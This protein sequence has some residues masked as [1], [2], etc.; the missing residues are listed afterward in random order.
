MREEILL[1]ETKTNVLIVLMCGFILINQ[2]RGIEFLLLAH[3][4]HNR[5][6]RREVTSAVT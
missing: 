6:K 3:R 2:Q 4:L 1:S 5:N